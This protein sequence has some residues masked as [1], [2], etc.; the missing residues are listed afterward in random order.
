MIYIYI[1]VIWHFFDIFFLG[2][3]AY[4]KGTASDKHMRGTTPHG[5]SRATTK[6]KK[7]IHDILGGNV[8]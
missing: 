6:K 4:N 8:K 7:N 3:F 1:F 2:H 5:E